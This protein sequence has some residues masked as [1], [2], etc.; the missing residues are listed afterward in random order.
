MSYM[1]TDN[2]LTPLLGFHETDATSASNDQDLSIRPEDTSHTFTVW[3]SD[4]D[5]SHWPVGSTE[6][7]L[8]LPAWPLYVMERVDGN[9]WSS[10]GSGSLGTRD[11]GSI[12]IFVKKKCVRVIRRKG[13][14]GGWRGEVWV[15]VV[16]FSW[17]YEDTSTNP[18]TARNVPRRI[19]HSQEPVSNCYV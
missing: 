6:I 7:V 11:S 8:T 1:D 15:K 3:S 9:G 2:K 16:P 4:P 14:G 18:S 19:A 10:L 12:W 13:G 5:A 17:S